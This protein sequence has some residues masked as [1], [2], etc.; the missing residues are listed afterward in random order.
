MKLVVLDRDGV[1]NEDSD[2][3]IKSIEE[4][5]P[6]PGSIAAIARLCKAGY[7]ITI[8][9]NQ[10]G[11]AR[12]FFGID[13]LNAMHERLRA[14]V[15]QQGG[16]I[17]SIFYCPHGPDDHC[18]CRKPKPGMLKK[19]LA[20]YAESAEA[21]IAIGDSKRDL[22]A[23]KAV[24]M[25]PILVRTGKGMKTVEQIKADPQLQD[26]PIYDDLAQAVDAIL[27]KA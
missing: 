1:I 23:A 4:F 26:T 7:T 24:G 13:T 16:A 20:E 12:G 19:I 17:D 14:L 2:A 9:T 11:I 25:Q 15:V 5:I 10:S 6:L 21:I 22:Q 27:A 18:D 8:A 3:Y